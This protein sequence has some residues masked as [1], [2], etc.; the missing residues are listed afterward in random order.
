MNTIYNTIFVN[1]EAFNC[2][3]QMSLYDL[4]T[5]MNFDVNTVIVEYNQEI[6]S[7]DNFNNIFFKNKDRLEI[8]TIVGG[9]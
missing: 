4:L 6:I 9:G 3:I 5:Y 2:F 7:C 1:G 8:I